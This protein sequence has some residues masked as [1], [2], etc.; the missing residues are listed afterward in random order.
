[1]K[2]LSLFFQ[3]KVVK[4]MIDIGFDPAAA[5]NDGRL[6]IHFL[7]EHGVEQSNIVSSHGSLAILTDLCKILVSNVTPMY[8]LP[9][10]NKDKRGG[11]SLLHFAIDAEMT[12]F[13]KYLIENGAKWKKKNRAGVM[14]LELAFSAK[15]ERF[16]GEVV[17]YMLSKSSSRYRVKMRTPLL[18][19]GA[20]FE[21]GDRVKVQH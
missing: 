9:K 2:R 20:Y 10:E 6:P 3:C 21:R 7:L 12:D 13:T 8:T 11:D 4:K 5:S 18:N 1:M 19:L 14:A 15:N 16:S 17:D